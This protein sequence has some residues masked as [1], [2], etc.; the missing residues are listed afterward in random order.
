MNKKLD[1][2]KQFIKQEMVDS[3]QLDDWF[4][5]EHILVVED[6][7]RKLVKQ[8]S[9]ANQEIVLLSVWLH[10]LGRAYGHD[11]DHDQWAA[12]FVEKYLAKHGFEQKII[13]GVKHA[14]LTHRVKDKQPKT[15]EAKILATADAL[16]HY[17]HTFYLRVF[18][19]WQQR[20]S[21]YQKIKQ[22]LFEK[23]QRDF[24]QKMFFEEAKDMV[25]EE[26]QAW[27]KILNE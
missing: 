3:A 27:M 23:I 24:N 25:R 2:I 5:P 20:I 21:D 15:L 6:F 14:C 1:K 10:D 7:A 4:W 22:K 13:D 26:Y 11:S 12:K 9:Q 17:R 8:H 18:Y 19:L 16:S